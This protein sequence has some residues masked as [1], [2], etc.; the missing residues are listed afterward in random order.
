[1]SMAPAGWQSASLGDVCRVVS[2]STPKTG[3]PDYWGGAI[4]WITPNDLS[5]DRS[6]VVHG[7]ERSLTAKGYESCSARLFPAGSVIVSSRAPIGYVAIAGAEMCTNQG[8]KTAVP[9]EFIDSRYLYWFLVNARPDL[10][11]RASGTTFRE[12]SGRRFAE[13]TFWWPPIAEQRRIV[14]ILEEHLS[15][16]DA[17]N[18][19]LGN[20]DRE[21]DAWRRAALDDLIWRRSDEASRARVIDLVREKM[22]NGHSA[23]A[24]RTGVGVRTLT[25]T[26]VTRNSFR[27]EFTKVAAADRDR[28]SDLWLRDGDIFVQRSNT[29]Q[30]VGSAAIYHGSEDWAIFPDLLIRVRADA[31]KV[32]SNYLAAVMRSERAHRFYRAHARGLAGSMPKIDQAVVGSLEIPMRPL[33]EQSDVVRAVDEV[34]AAHRHLIDGI[35]AA[36]RRREVLVSSLLTAAFSGQLTG[37]SV[38]PTVPELASV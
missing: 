17:A 4:A 24:S 10:E 2:G 5:K 11:A 13:T 32:L 16:L 31:N 27:D 18:A 1:M 38:E 21:V 34:E 36:R 28:V 30:L 9:P 14:Q 37:A 6:Q 7:G 25:I 3:E 15:R 22:R 8:C 20:S 33:S 29:A 19:Q 35:D 23:R 26:A 12:I